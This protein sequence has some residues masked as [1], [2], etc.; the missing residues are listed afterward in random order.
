MFA[1]ILYTGKRA[2]VAIVHH[3]LF[4]R[5]TKCIYE[6]QLAKLLRMKVTTRSNV[7]LA[8]I[9]PASFKTSMALKVGSVYLVHISK[10]LVNAERY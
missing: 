10:A 4:F 1:M 2:V 9:N 3:L 6:R 7:N 5:K 8:G